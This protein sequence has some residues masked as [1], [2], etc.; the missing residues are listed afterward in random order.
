MEYDEII[1]KVSYAYKGGVGRVKVLAFSKNGYWKNSNLDELFPPKGCVFAPNLGNDYPNIKADDIIRFN[2]I[3][4]PYESTDAEKDKMII[5]SKKD[6]GTV[7]KCPQILNVPLEN[8]YKRESVC[9]SKEVAFFFYRQKNTSLIAGPIWSNNL[10]PQKGKEVDAWTFR[11]GYDTITDPATNMTYLTTDVKEFTSKDPTCSIDCMSFSQLSDWFKGKLE[12]LVPLETLKTVKTAMKEAADGT[13]DI[14]KQR[15]ARVRQSFQE[16]SLGWSEIQCLKNIEGFDTRI[17]KAIQDNI[18]TFFQK[19]KDLVEQERHAITEEK[20]KL[21]ASLVEAKKR[22]DEDLIKIASEFEHSKERYEKEQADVNSL[23]ASGQKALDTLTE[24]LA[25]A[26][27]QKNDLLAQK[28]AIIASIKIQAETF[29][30]RPESTP[31]PGRFSYPLETV[32]RRTSATKVATK[33]TEDKFLKKLNTEYEQ[34]CKILDIRSALRR[35][36]IE[37]GVV[38]DD[39]RNGIALAHLLG[40]TVFQLVQPSPKWISFK[41]FYEE[42]LGT[43][44]TSAHENPDCWHLLMIENF[45]IA[46]PECYG[47]PLWNLLRGKTRKLP[48]ATFP[49][50][51]PNLRIIVSAAPCQSEDNSHM[52][53]P[54]HVIDGWKEINTL[55]QTSWDDGYW[56]DFS[57]E[58]Y[59]QL[60][61]NDSYYFEIVE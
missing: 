31:S 21:K 11:S 40:N 1:G 41:D 7:V 27:K 48:M 57:D 44:W 29:C 61:I 18:G 34:L 52:G 42:S 55:N 22:Y 32:E 50:F 9:N 43:I 59:N 16:L 19:E 33:Q 35:L 23:L 45:N 56:F 38:V 20:E 3:E 58:T 6:H 54:T 24:E 49:E 36:S 12:N 37:S 39:I 25:E 5:P 47:M 13:D 26:E 28:D 17:R 8:I 46:L 14:T 30:Q 10:S 53:L 15:F 51:P 4:N 2:C 60:Q